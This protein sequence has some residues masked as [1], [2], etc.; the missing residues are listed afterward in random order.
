MTQG[1]KALKNK[2][3]GAKSG[4]GGWRSAIFKDNLGSW[5]ATFGLF[6]LP[7]TLG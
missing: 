3:L 2:A 7:I 5:I 6:S 4:N 1:F